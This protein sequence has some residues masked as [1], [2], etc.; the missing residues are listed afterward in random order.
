MVFV[1][2]GFGLLCGMTFS[3]SVNRNIFV[4]T[5]ASLLL[6]HYKYYEVRKS[7]G[8]YGATQSDEVEHYIKSIFK[9]IAFF[10]LFIGPAFY[11]T[12]VKKIDFIHGQN[13]GKDDDSD[14]AVTAE[15]HYATILKQIKQKEQ[16]AQVSE[17]STA[18]VDSSDGE[19]EE[20]RI[21]FADYEALMK[22]LE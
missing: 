10:T 20:P 9:G 1:G 11:L 14:K 2:L 3:F 6:P 8:K 13:A 22:K 21:T 12:H 17:Q 7:R 18:I 15:D 16:N 4:F 19:K 5:Q